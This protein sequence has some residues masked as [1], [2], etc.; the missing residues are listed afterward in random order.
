MK[1]LYLECAMGAAGDMLM[2]ALLEL[3]DDPAD[4]LAAVNGLGLAGVRVTAVPDH[5]GAIAGTRIDVTVDGHLEDSG[6]PHGHPHPH[7]HPH[8]HPDPAEPLCSHTH[9]DTAQP[10]CSHPHPDSTEQPPTHDHHTHQHP[11][12]HS[13]DHLHP[14]SHQSA[15][16]AA[17]GPAG[18]QEAL[19]RLA[20]LP[21]SDRVRADAVAV[22]RLIAE[23]EAKVHG[24]APSQVHFHEVGHL[25]AVADIVG[26]CLLMERLAPDRVVAS[27][28]HV[29]RGFT[30]CAHG[31]LPVP[32]PATAE[33]LRGLPTWAGPIEGELCTPT[34]AALLKHF[35]TA[36]GPQPAMTV[37]RIGY[38][39]GHR[40]FDRPNCLRAFWGDQPEDSPARAVGATADR[41]AEL[42]CNLD[43]M[44][45][46]AVAY[47]CDLLRQAGARDV[48]LTPVMMKKGRPGQLLTCLCDLADADRLT[49][50]ML[51]HTTTFGVRRSD[52][53]RTILERQTTV[54]ATPYGD[55]RV[56]TGQGWGVAKAKAE[57]DDV[58]AAA[59]RHGLP[60]AAVTPVL[61]PPQPTDLPVSPSDPLAPPSDTS[62]PLPGTPAPPSGTPASLPGTPAAPSDTPASLPDTLAPPSD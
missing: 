61:A 33:L 8:P 26:V 10:R 16:D 35:A 12:P 60:L 5:R 51:A 38:G 50:L 40:D 34:G 27:P 7:E 20:A 19:A 3:A 53:Q 6:A 37:S 45:G 62:A 52:C 2:A 46:E 9:S 41:V 15:A 32:A 48:F 59:T 47:A 4:C 25:D 13:H 23:A 14:H 18:L 42:R 55:I 54:R 39:L 1:T 57:H 29:G 30:R 49:R 22:Y 58:A 56:K 21:V 44:A 17:H 24:C 28:V 31:V 11:H 36:F 43:D